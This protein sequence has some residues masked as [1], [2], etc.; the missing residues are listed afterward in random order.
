MYRPLLY[1]AILCFIIDGRNI[2]SSV[3]Y[4]FTGSEPLKEM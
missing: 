1:L 4:K 2:N 3:F